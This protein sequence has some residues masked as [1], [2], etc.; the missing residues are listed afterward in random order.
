LAWLSRNQDITLIYF[1]KSTALTKN[2]SKKE[3]KIKEI[4][5]TR[6]NNVSDQ[7][8]EL[9]IYG[10]FDSR[11]RGQY[12]LIS[13]FGNFRTTEFWI[14]D[15]QENK[16]SD[17]HIAEVAAGKSLNCPHASCSCLRQYLR[18]NKNPYHF[19]W[20][21]LTRNPADFKDIDENS[22]IVALQENIDF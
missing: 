16:Q 6:V 13:E 5:P 9:I 11:N 14:V 19:Y 7:V 20:I 22:K 8:N 21:T 18:Y 10:D 15:I 17:K 12:L 4:I 1:D 3:F 2:S